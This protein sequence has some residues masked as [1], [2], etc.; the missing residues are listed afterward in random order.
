MNQET[1][2]DRKR[3]LARERKRKQRQNEAEHKAAVGA[4]QFSFEIYQ[5][6]ANALQVICKAGD[7]EQP[8]EVLTLLI[9]GAA[10]LAQRDRSRFNELVSVTSHA[11]GLTGD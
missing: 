2:E 3:R 4:Q 5:G 8:A 7:F 9:H 10:E 11:G 6:T 1:K